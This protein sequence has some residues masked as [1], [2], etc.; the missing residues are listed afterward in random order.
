MEERDYQNG[1]ERSINSPASSSVNPPRTARD[2][3]LQINQQFV[4]YRSCL[5]P[6]GNYQDRDRKG[7]KYTGL[8]LRK[9]SLEC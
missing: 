3:L 2:T 1:A 9:P 5:N 8:T 6:L 7:Y 4:Y